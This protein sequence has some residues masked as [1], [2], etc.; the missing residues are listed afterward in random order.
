[1]TMKLFEIPDLVRRRYCDCC[2]LPTLGVPD[3]DDG[4]ADW[5]SAATACDLCEWENVSLDDAGMAQVGAS[6]EDANDGLNLAMA[7]SN[8]AQFMSIYDPSA[9]PEWKVAAPST[10]VADGRAALATALRE[11]VADSQGDEYGKWET[12]EILERE[13]RHALEAQRD[14]EE[15]IMDAVSEDSLD[16]TEGP[17]AADGNTGP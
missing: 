14:E 12:V 11:L 9:L 10:E 17:S 13:L 8:F 5:M 2:C 4:A 3:D 7:Q 15:D 1:M 6:E 16:G